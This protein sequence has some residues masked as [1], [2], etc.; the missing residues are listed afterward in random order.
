MEALINPAVRDIQIS[1]IRR[2][3]SLVARVPDAIA[4]TIGQPDFPTPDH[5][6]EAVHRAIRLNRTAYT[7]NAGLPELREAAAAFLRAR[8]GL[9]YDPE[10][11]VIV[12]VGASEAIAI[13]LHT[14]LEPGCEVILPGPV[15]PGYEPLIRLCGA[16]PVY[17]DTR[18][19]GFKLTAQELR[20]RLSPRTRVVILP[21]PSNPTGQVLGDA[22]LAALAEVLAERDVMVVSDEIYSELVFS[23]T[24]RSI[25][26]YPGMRERTIVV[27]GLSKSH[28]M[29]GWRIGFTFAPAPVTAHLLKVHQYFVTCASSVS[30]YAALQALTEGIHDARAMRDEYA[31]RGDF[32]H[33]RLREMGLSA[34]KPEGAFYIFPSIQRFGLTSFEFARRLLE[35]GKVAVVPGDAF[36]PLGEG[37]VRMSFACRMDRLE[38]AMERIEEFIQKAFGQSQIP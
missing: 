21:Y 24:H 11:E 4:L 34:V 35:E 32:V 20:R 27:N 31:R 10:S 12:T 37:Y 2:F 1:G 17:A 9:E 5:V 38:Q 6:K 3:A 23:D 36:S 26:S 30:Q 28:A 16:T 33:R 25:A 18:E 7:P 29:T 13:A 22:D 19:S 14:V 8:Y 15:Y